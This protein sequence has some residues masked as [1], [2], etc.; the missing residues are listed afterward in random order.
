MSEIHSTPMGRRDAIAA[1]GALALAA[2][3]SDRTTAPPDA[4][5][6]EVEM[7]GIAFDPPTVSIQV[8]DRVTWRNVGQFVHTAT[9]DPSKANDPS[10]AQRPPG[11]DPWDSG[12]VAVGSTFSR[13]FDVAGEYNYFC[14]PHEA[15]GMLGTIIVT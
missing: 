12:A 5:G 15:Q 13:V 3:F 9:C 7:V 2:C 14:I 4:G 6:V 11:A 1:I 10:N 8:G